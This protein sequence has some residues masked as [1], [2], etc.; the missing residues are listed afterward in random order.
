MDRLLKV[1]SISVALSISL[2]FTPFVRADSKETRQQEI[3][4]KWQID[5]PSFTGNPFEKNSQLKTP[6]YEGKLKSQFIQDGIKMTNFVRFL[7]GVQDDIVRDTE[8]EDM[9]Q[10]GAVLIASSQFSHTAPKPA[11]MSEEF[12]KDAYAGTSSSNI[13]MGSVIDSAANMVVFGNNSA[14]SL[15]GSIREG[16][17]DDSDLGN[18]SRVGHRRWILNPE[19]SKVAFGYVKK[20][21]PNQ[22]MGMAYSAMRV[23]D[24]SRKNTADY[25]IVAWPGQGSFPYE[26]FDKGYMAWSVSLNTQKYDIKD[27]KKV[28][29][30]LRR[31]PDGKVWS[32]DLNQNGIN[33]PSQKAKYFNI[34]K[35]GY[36]I[37][38]CLIFRPDG[39]ENYKNG[40]SFDISIEGVTDRSGAD[41]RI[42]Y[43][44]NF[45]SLFPVKNIKFS[46]P[47]VTLYTDQNGKQL[48]ADLNVEESNTK[49]I[50]YTTNNPSVIK[51]YNDGYVNPL[52]AGKAIVTAEC[53][54]KKATCVVTVITPKYISYYDMKPSNSKSNSNNSSSSSSSKNSGST[55]Y[56]YS[57]NNINCTTDNNESKLVFAIKDP[58]VFI[59]LTKKN[60][61]VK[62]QN[63]KIQAFTLIKDSKTRNI[64][65]KHSNKF[66][67][68]VTYTCILKSGTIKNSFTYTIKYGLR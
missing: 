30:I 19:L 48:K 20:S 9:A 42:N 66:K 49:K 46:S 13:F 59:A 5:K 35:G 54:G 61:T 51:L 65:I 15:W 21:Y 47:N 26:F 50:T 67:K 41:A 6:Y 28:K 34:E 57:W 8:K 7:S 18:I 27:D 2:T 38:L 52:K 37:P 56:D 44:A 62:D 64:T 24:M 14:D 17:M 1:C 25:N 60:F 40:E 11:G 36:G 55:N 33:T 4:E 45:F 12:Y 32:F 43:S 10:K 3:M 29:L 53:E 58:S 68:G 22:F 31:K 23:F 63:G 16:Y 39:I